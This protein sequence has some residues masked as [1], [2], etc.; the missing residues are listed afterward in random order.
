M[1]LDGCLKMSCDIL[2]QN[3]LAFDYHFSFFVE[4]H[5][6]EY[7]ASLSWYS[8]EEMVLKDDRILHLHEKVISE[9]EVCFCCCHCILFLKVH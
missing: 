4:R 7:L 8:P 3:N 5:F 6:L 9:L 1:Q 2:C